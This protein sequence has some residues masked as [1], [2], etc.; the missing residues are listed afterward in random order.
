[1]VVPVGSVADF[2]RIFSAIEAVIIAAYLVSFAAIV[3]LIVVL[4]AGI[5]TRLFT[6]T[7]A[8]CAMCGEV[9]WC[10]EVNEQM[11]CTQCRMDV[12]PAKRWWEP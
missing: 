11:L 6:P 3:V 8:T 5:P 9:G 2:V 12:T 10:K 1:M 7:E 4:V